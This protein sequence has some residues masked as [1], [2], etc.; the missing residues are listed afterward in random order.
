MA[1]YYQHNNKINIDRYGDYPKI[2]GISINNPDKFYL[3]NIDTVSELG[4]LQ[5]S[6]DFG[7]DSYIQNNITYKPIFK[8]YNK[9]FQ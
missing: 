6:L 8:L 1:I 9:F 5:Y 2:S 4:S 3:D 7:S